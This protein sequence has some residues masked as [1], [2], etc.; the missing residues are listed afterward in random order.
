MSPSSI[1]L[2]TMQALIGQPLG[3]SEWRTVSQTDIN[4][5]AEITGD[6]QF[7]HVDA[8]KAATTL[9]G[10]TIA[11][12]FLTLSL[13]SVLANG[14]IPRLIGQKMSVNYGFNRI[15]FTSPV[16]SGSRIKARFQLNDIV[17]IKPDHYQISTDVIVFIEHQEKPA[18]FANW[19]SL[20]VF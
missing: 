17:Q 2:K 20:A 15:R 12:G 18:L 5:F 1:T 8:N 10:T 4:T 19:L 7:I 6:H 13:L 9:F 14:I 16:P 11:H 3:E